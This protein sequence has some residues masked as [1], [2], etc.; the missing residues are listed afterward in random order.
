[1][2]ILP[3]GLPRIPLPPSRYALRR[4]R[5]P[6]DP[7]EARKASEGAAAPCGYGLLVVAPEI[8]HRQRTPQVRGNLAVPDFWPLRRV[9]MPGAGLEIAQ[10]LVFH[11][12]ELDVEL[13]VLIV[14]VAVVD[15][16]VVAGPVAHRPP[17]DRHLAQRQEL[18][19][20]LQVGEI[21]EL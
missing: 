6:A 5:V 13:D 10:L 15:R 21:F 12:V 19:G 8:R 2:V 3:I 14:G 16:D 7:A 17:V 1:P 20:V 9:V 4:T 11:L 18:A